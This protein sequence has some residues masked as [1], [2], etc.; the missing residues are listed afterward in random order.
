MSENNSSDNGRL[1][2]YDLIDF[3]R[4]VT[5]VDS[6]V[7][8]TI[9]HFVSTLF[10]ISAYSYDPVSEMLKFL[11]GASVEL[12]I[13]YDP[14]I[15]PVT[16]YAGDVVVCNFGKHVDGEVSGHHVNALVCDVCDNGLVYLIP[17]TKQ[18]IT[19]DVRRYMPIVA[20]RDVFY[21]ADTHYKSGTLL[22]QMGK[23]FR[24][25]RIRKVVGTVPPE[26]YTDVV[27][28]L[29]KALDFLNE[30]PEIENPATF[31]EEELHPTPVLESPVQE[32]LSLGAQ[33][34]SNGSSPGTE[35]EAPPVPPKNVAKKKASSSTRKPSYETFL[36]NY[37]KSQ[38]DYVDNSSPALQT[39]KDFLELIHFK[40]ELGLIEDALAGA[41]QLN[42]ITY[43]SVVKY[44]RSLYPLTETHIKEVIVDYY[45]SWLENNPQITEQ[46][47]N[48][49][50][51]T[52]LTVFAKKY[53]GI[54]K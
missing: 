19:G 8:K 13:Q 36:T 1:V 3:Q 49:S 53:N 26:F 45:R 20:N 42:R 28:R 44:L 31:P 30:F 35:H 5:F 51:T 54:S 38:L 10:D 40:D 16:V 33:M 4:R 7:R 47:P 24:V 2:I 50:I 18:L 22:L 23:Y 12:S 6:E 48:T 34:S 46:Y 17:I 41:C 14:T 43:Q 52:L 25:E 11:Y 37:L 39:A 29:H 27:H 15:N 9:S 32:D 21:N